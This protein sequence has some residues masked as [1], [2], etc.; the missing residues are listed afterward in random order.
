MAQMH[1]IYEFLLKTYGRNEPIFTE[2]LKMQLDISPQSFRQAVMKLVDN[3][4]I[5]MVQRGIYFIPRENT[6]LGK[7][8]LSVEKIVERKYLVKQGV[9][10][11]Y[12]SGINLAN[13]LGLTRQTASVPTIITNNTAAKKREVKFY[14]RRVIIKKPKFPIN[15]TNWKVFQM[16]DLMAHFNEW[17]EVPLDKVKPYLDGYFRDVAVLEPEL[18]EYLDAY[19]KRTKENM[20]KAGIYTPSRIR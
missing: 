12:K 20:I 4:L 10:I 16:L 17:S 5:L 14:N 19:P 7:P 6:L 15:E 9:R 11:G 18:L 8:V 1:D 3:G 13:S 2:E